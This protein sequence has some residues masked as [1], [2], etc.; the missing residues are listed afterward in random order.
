MLS[1]IS[2][3]VR[4]CYY[5][6]YYLA[7]VWKH[8]KSQ[9]WTACFRDQ[10]GRRRRIST[11]E[12][13]NKKALKIAEEFERAA[14]TKRTLEWVQVI[15]DRLR[16]EVSGER[17]I[18]STLIT[19]HNLRSDELMGQMSDNLRGQ[20]GAEKSVQISCNSLILWDLCTLFSHLERS[21]R[22]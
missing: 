15:L 4:G 11:E 14:G 3:D 20:V 19:S 2:V 6:C 17:V 10:N 13:N 8:P 5:F 12:T 21:R 22:L 18:R 16:E 7:S 1:W 9:H